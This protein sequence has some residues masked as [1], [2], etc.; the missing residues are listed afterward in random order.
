MSEK[1]A[2]IRVDEVKKELDWLADVVNFSIQWSPEEIVK[3]L[4]TNTVYFEAKK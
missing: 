2:Y 3:W 4:E 1:T